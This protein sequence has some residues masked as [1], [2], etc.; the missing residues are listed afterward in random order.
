MKKFNFL[1]VFINLQLNYNSPDRERTQ[2][3]SAILNEKIQFSKGFH[4][5]TTEL[6]LA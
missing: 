5:F 3:N 6:Q 1:R 2:F 4:Q